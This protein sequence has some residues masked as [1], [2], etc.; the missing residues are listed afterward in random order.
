MLIISMDLI[1][2]RLHGIM[3]HVACYL[4]QKDHSLAVRPN[5]VIHLGAYSLPGQLRGSKARLRHTSTESSTHWV[6]WLK[7][8]RTSSPWALLTTSISVL[9][10]PMLQTI[11]PFFMRS[12]WSLVTTF[13]FPAERHNHSPSV[14]GRSETSFYSR[15][16]GQIGSKRA[17]LQ[18]ELPVH[19]MM[20]STWRITSFS[21]TTLNPSMLG[22]EKKMFSVRPHWGQHLLST[23]KMLNSAKV[24]WPRAVTITTTS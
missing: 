6:G 4:S 21:L 5:H 19:V 14:T 9:E 20:I 18:V 11:E 15:Q 7:G 24:L 10:W 2:I 3:Y 1:H 16:M 23:D 12:S 13:L 17:R 22:K 8:T